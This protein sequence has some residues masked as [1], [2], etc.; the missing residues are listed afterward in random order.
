M[1]GVSR[2]FLARVHPDG[3]TDTSFTASANMPV[4]AIAPLVDGRI[5]VGGDFTTFNGAT[6]NRLLQLLPDG[7]RDSSFNLPGRE[8]RPA[9][10]AT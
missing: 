3:S 5:L 2:P 7:S 8:S 1:N 9:P 4:R 6:D 10:R